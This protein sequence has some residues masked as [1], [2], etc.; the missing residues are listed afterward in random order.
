MVSNGNRRTTTRGSACNSHFHPRLSF[1]S[2]PSGL[3]GALQC[4][5]T[6]GVWAE[7]ALLAQTVSSRYPRGRSGSP[8]AFYHLMRPHSC[9]GRLD[10]ESDVRQ[11]TATK[12]TGGLPSLPPCV[13][14]SLPLCLN[15]GVAPSPVAG[16][17]SACRENQICRGVGFPESARS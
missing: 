3:L 2:V 7:H 6:T 8:I 10:A 9:R 1:E 11:H 14:A 4:Q 5:I 15:P 12:N 16:S 13:L 17:E